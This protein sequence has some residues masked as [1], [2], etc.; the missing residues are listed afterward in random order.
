VS[1]LAATAAE[2]AEKAAACGVPGAQ[3][4]LCST[5]YD[6]TGSQR[7]AEIGDDLSVPLRILLIILVAF[8]LVRIV[9]VVVRRTVR[10]MQQEQTGE[11]ISKIK[12]RTGLALLDTSPV[13]GVRRALRA[14]TIGAVMRSVASIIIWATALLMVLDELGVNLAAIGIGASIIG[15]AIGFGSQALVKDFLSGLFM[16]LEDQY[17]VGDVIDTGVATGTVEGVSLRTTRLRDAEGTVWHIPN[18]GILRVGN[19]SQQWTRVILDV[20]VAY[21]ADIE[22]ATYVIRSAAENLAADPDFGPVITE[23]PEIWGIEQVMSDHV[24]IRLAVKTEPLEQW[25]VA[26]ALRARL[27]A[28]LDDAGIGPASESVITYRSEGGAPASDR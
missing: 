11:R 9:R 20:S 4:W 14:E 5:V 1:L 17:G 22:R 27:K 8:V 6:V 21:D 13:M 10:K 28:A 24:L 2:Q 26:R 3:S 7:A 23:T 12:Q 19:K 16:L 15:V 25:R 18:G